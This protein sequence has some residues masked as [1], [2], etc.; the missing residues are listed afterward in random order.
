MKLRYTITKKQ[1]TKKDE[2]MRT[3]TSVFFLKKEGKNTPVSQ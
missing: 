2:Q 3:L 1:K